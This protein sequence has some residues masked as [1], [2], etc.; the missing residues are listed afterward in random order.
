M[1]NL[2]ALSAQIP[3]QA[4]PPAEQHAKLQQAARDLEASFLAEMLKA[5]GLGKTRDAFGGGAGE[6]HFASFLAEAHAKALVQSGGI[7]LAESIFNALKEKH[8]AP[9]QFE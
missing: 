3:A 1:T 9:T 5:A 7:G 4:G 8:D 2:K 6:E